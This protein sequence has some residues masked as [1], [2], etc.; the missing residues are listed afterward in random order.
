MGHTKGVALPHPSAGTETCGVLIRF[1]R[2][3][4]GRILSAEMS[5]LVSR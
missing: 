3:L 1:L 2:S 5:A 4:T